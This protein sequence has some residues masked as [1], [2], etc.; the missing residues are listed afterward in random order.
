MEI[1]QRAQWRLFFLEV[2]GAD[3]R[4]R[5]LIAL[6]LNVAGLLGVEERFGSVHTPLVALLEV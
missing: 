2:V 4:Y 1:V 3:Q 6:L 5:Y